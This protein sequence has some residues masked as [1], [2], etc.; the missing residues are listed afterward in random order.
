MFKNKDLVNLYLE[1]CVKILDTQKCIGH[2]L[3]LLETSRLFRYVL[4]K[5]QTVWMALWDS[6]WFQSI[7]DFYRFT[8][9]ING[10]IRAFRI[11]SLSYSLCTLKEIYSMLVSKDALSVFLEIYK[12]FIPSGCNY[13]GRKSSLDKKQYI[14]IGTITLYQSGKIFFYD[15]SLTKPKDYTI[16]L[17]KFY[18]PYKN[19]F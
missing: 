7:F 15:E 8:P 4:R 5:K 19:L 12:A 17:E 6:D 14:V 18:T 16:T 11:V 13:V 9:K 3:R 2:F 10:A 1:Q